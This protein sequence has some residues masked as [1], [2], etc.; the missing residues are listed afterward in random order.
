M[1][2][3]YNRKNGEERRVLRRGER[4]GRE[5]SM[6]V[7]PGERDSSWRGA[8]EAMWR[9]EHD[10]VVDVLDTDFLVARE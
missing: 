2:Q 4:E 5:V 1:S 9:G 8:V 10:D 6:A 3:E 7:I